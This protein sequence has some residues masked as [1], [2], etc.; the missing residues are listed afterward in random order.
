MARRS[1]SVASARARSSAA[2]LPARPPRSRGPAARS[3]ARFYPAGSPARD[4]AQLAVEDRLERIL[5]TPLRT[6]REV[7]IPIEGDLRAWEAR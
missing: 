4:R 1:A 7:P 3:F 6:V 2:V 5:G